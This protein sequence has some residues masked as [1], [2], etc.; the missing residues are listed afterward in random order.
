MSENKESKNSLKRKKKN[1]LIEKAAAATSPLKLFKMLKE[2]NQELPENKRFSI[3]STT[4]LC[5]VFDEV[6]KNLTNH[7]DVASIQARDNKGLSSRNLRRIKLVITFEDSEN[8]Y[9]DSFSA[10]KRRIMILPLP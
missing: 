5:G 9:K 10:D 6:R 1:S 8:C 7:K 2:Y 4:C 3:I